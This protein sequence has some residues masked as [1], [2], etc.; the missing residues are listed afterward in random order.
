MLTAVVL[1]G[2]LALVAAVVGWLCGF[3]PWYGLNRRS[4]DFESFSR[5]LLWG[6][7]ATTPAVAVLL[8]EDS[9]WLL[10]LNQLK[11]QVVE[12][13]QRLMRGAR[14]WQL[15]VISLAAGIGE[16]V[17][18]RGLI[19]AGLMELLPTSFAVVGSLL[20]ASVLFG[21]C[22]YLSHTYFILATLAGVYFGLVML[23]TGSILPAILA[24][25]LY[26]FIALA[27]LLHDDS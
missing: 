19:Q 24:H 12:L 3:D 10:P 21:L 20:I 6:I 9:D 1:E 5:E 7:A 25:A 23:I 14:L 16:E 4:Y 27:Y 17:L 11:E 8:I 13:L 15:F 2:G 26:D 18:F 22:H